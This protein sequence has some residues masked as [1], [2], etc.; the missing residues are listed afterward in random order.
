MLFQFFICFIDDGYSW[1]ATRCSTTFEMIDMNENCSFDVFEGIFNRISRHV[2]VTADCRKQ[3]KK[4][5][6]KME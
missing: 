6:I 4:I 3:Q 2:Y 5:H 1:T